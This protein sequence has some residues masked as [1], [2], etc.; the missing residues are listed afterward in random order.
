VNI[1]LQLDIT[2]KNI[3]LQLDNMTMSLQL[4]LNNSPHNLQLQLDDSSRIFPLQLEILTAQPF[5][6]Y[7]LSWLIMWGFVL[8]LTVSTTVINALHSAEVVHIPHEY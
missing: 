2:T 5:P 8:L 4:Q 6:N 1:Q 7:Q 3:Q